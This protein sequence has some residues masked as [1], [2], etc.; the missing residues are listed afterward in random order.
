MQQNESPF[1]LFLNAIPI[2]TRVMLIS[3]LSFSIATSFYP[4]IGYLSYFDEE[5][6]TERF[7]VWRL[8]T[9]F[10]VMRM[11][12]PFIMHLLMLYK[13]SAEL[14]ESYFNNTKD[15]VLYLL[16]ILGLIDTFSVLYVPLH[17]QFITCIV[18]TCC[19]ADPESV[20]S[21]LFGITLKRKYVPWALIL[22]NVLMGSQLLPSFV[23]IAIAHCY[24][25]VRHVIPV[26]YPQ[27][28]RLI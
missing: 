12:F 2:C 10:F 16:F 8:F 27:I 13:F 11:G 7:Q 9:P 5:E 22:L 1:M 17:Q 21:F 19:R 23:L 14:E 3:T 20:M 15:Y 26:H 4:S 6:I 25:F 18:Y 28:P 24:Y